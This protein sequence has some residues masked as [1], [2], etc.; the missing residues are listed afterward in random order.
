MKKNVLL[1]SPQPYFQWRGSPI[2]VSFNLL[3]LSKLGYDVHLLTLPIG[4]SRDVAGVR[5]IRVANPFGIKNVPI[6]P[7]L[8]KVFFDMLLMAKG[9]QLCLKNRYQVVHGIEEAGFIAGVLARLIGAKTIFEKHSDP[10]SYKSGV[11]KNLVLRAYAGVERLS[12]RMADAVIG[13][14]PGLVEQVD[15][16]Q[17]GTRS[18]NIFDIPSSLQEPDPERVAK[19]RD[20]LQHH[21]NEVLITFVGSFAVYQGV[22]LMFAAIPLVLDEVSNARFLIIGGTKQEIQERKAVLA[23][24]GLENRVTFLGK[25]APDILPDYLTAS[26]I[27]LS[28]RISGVNTPLK[29]LDYMKAGRPI[30]ATD[31][32]ANRLLLTDKN[33]LLAAPEPKTYADA[34]CRLAK[35]SGL[36]KSMERENRRLHEEKYNFAEYQK[37]LAACYQYTLQAAGEGNK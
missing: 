29:I 2:R 19:L 28:P 13:T 5:I 8:V 21:E 33:G 4:E 10:F 26:D 37:R 24:K 36:R 11:L 30:V 9:V 17:L 14:G 31:V 25:I 3:A 34:I 16:M 12:I 15:Q 27:L 7:S 22:D 23:E 20:T 32:Q 1:I 6:G 18:F 35:D